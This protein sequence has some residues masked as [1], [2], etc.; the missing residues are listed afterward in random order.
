MQNGKLNTDQRKALVKLVQA[1]YSRKLEDQRRLYEM[2]MK[3]ITAEVKAE[4]GVTKMDEE[5]KKLQAR[6]KV[7]EESKE[8]LGFSKYN[9][10]L[11]PGTKA[12]K[13][14]EERSSSEK[15]KLKALESEMDKAISS[16][17]VAGEIAEIAHII[18]AVSPD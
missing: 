6:T 3:E 14:V 4:L 12:G 13:L 11:L 8:E 9:D 7:L 18:D 2:A 10:H 15:E 17:W 1:S 16:I 5:L